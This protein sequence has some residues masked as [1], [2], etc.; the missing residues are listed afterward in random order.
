MGSV[1]SIRS[2]VTKAFWSTL[3]VAA[4]VV[5]SAFGPV[6]PAPAGASAKSFELIALDVV[7]TIA[8]D[9]S[10][11][12]TESITYRFVGGPFTIGTR[13]FIA[14]DRDRILDFRAFSGEFEL[15]TVAPDNTP[16]GEWEWE[17]PASVTDDLATYRLEYT[18]PRAVTIGIDVGELYWQFLG[19]DHPGIDAVSVRI[20]LP[21]TFVPATVTTSPDEIAVLRA[22]GHGPRR[23]TI[24]LAPDAVEL[25]VT[26]VPAGEFV[27]ARVAIPGDV[28][29]ADATSGPR[30]ADILSEE[31]AAI[32]R[33]LAEDRGRSYDPPP[34][35]LAR[36]LGP[37]GALVGLVGAGGLWARFGREPRPGPLIG[38]YWREPLT[39]PP[40]VVLANLAKGEVGLS[41]G[42]AATIID[43]AQRGHLTIREER[44]D[45]F[46][47]DK[48]VRHLTRT[49]KP[50]T[51]LEPFERRLM[52][53]VF[54]NG[55]HTTVDDITEQAKD[56]KTAS[57]AFAS[58]FTTDIGRAY[59][60]RRYK[61]AGN[62]G[63]KWIVV[64]ALASAAIGG[65]GLLLGTNLGFVGL[66]GAVVA[67]ML[68]GVG[69]VNRTQAGA[70]EAAKAEGLKKYIEDF[71]HLADAPAGHLV[72]WERFLVFAVALGVSRELLDGL[73]TRLPQ[74]LDDPG[75]GGWYV[76]PGPRRFDSFE[77][78]PGEFG[79]ATAVAVAPSKSGSGGGFSGG[80]GGGGGGGGFG[81]R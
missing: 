39:D 45:R 20:E 70:D 33:T 19:S 43:L 26:G 58:G 37:I 34:S 35:T 54:R 22:W 55:P 38:E 74:V 52:A 53:F 30:L 11:A 14:E 3:L 72:L 5:G 63:R 46:G 51:D 13:S 8:R 68:A 79:R 71:S 27:E 61:A 48:T 80:G 23:G 62:P 78:F 32:D 36:L 57:T 21:G 60:E 17:F 50:E 64:V 24:T 56:D 6:A 1:R 59:T 18:V 42:I 31:G 77:R 10:M 12:V 44:V 29:T 25:N 69:L 41:D 81:A 73:A 28:F 66:G 76:G 75:F 7:A 9:G 40:A 16:T 65:F 47:P 49:D 4:S 15:V 67:A 2:R